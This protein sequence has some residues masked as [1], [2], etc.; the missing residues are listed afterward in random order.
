MG[1]CCMLWGVRFV[2]RRRVASLVVTLCLPCPGRRFFTDFITGTDHQLT[3]H[4][5][6][7]A[8]RQSQFWGGACNANQTI[9][10]AGTISRALRVK[11]YNNRAAV[12]VTLP[13]LLCRF[14]N[15]GIG[16][17]G[18]GRNRRSRGP[19]TAIPPRPGCAVCRV[20]LR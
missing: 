7:A 1:G 13:F 3:Y 12:Y 15:F 11:N 16:A 18:P 5:N 9:T 2:S 19:M 8:A 10:R 17:G 14:D 6:G 4:K 20:P